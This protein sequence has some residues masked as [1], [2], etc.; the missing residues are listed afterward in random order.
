[1]KAKLLST[2]NSLNRQSSILNEETTNKIILSY[3][4]SVSLFLKDLKE[5]YD[6]Y[7]SNKEKKKRKKRDGGNSKLLLLDNTSSK[8]GA[9][10]AKEDDNNNKKKRKR[11]DDTENKKSSSWFAVLNPINWFSSSSSD[12]KRVKITP[13]VNDQLNNLIRKESTLDTVKLMIEEQGKSMN[14]II[15]EQ[16]RNQGVYNPTKMI[17]SILSSMMSILPI[18]LDTSAYLSDTLLPPS[19]IISKLGEDDNNNVKYVT[20]ESPVLPIFLVSEMINYTQPRFGNL[21]EGVDAVTKKV[22]KEG[23]RDDGNDNN[24]NNNNTEVVVME[25][26][27]G[28]SDADALSLKQLLNTGLGLINTLCVID[29]FE[30]KKRLLFDITHGKVTKPSNYDSSNNNDALPELSDNSLFRHLNSTVSF[31]STPW[32]LFNLSTNYGIN[33]LNKRAMYGL[34]ITGNNTK[35]DINKSLSRTFFEYDDNM[36]SKSWQYI[37]SS[38]TTTSSNNKKSYPY[39]ASGLFI[40]PEIKLK[41][42][43]SDFIG[44]IIGSNSNDKEEEEEVVFFNKVGDRSVQQSTFVMAPNTNKTTDTTTANT[45]SLLLNTE[46]CDISLL[47][48]MCDTLHYKTSKEIEFSEKVTKR[49]QSG[50]TPPITTLSID[51]Y[52]SGINKRYLEDL[53]KLSGVL[54]STQSG[55]RDQYINNVYE[56]LLQYNKDYFVYF[57]PSSTQGPQIKSDLIQLSDKLRSMYGKLSK[58]HVIISYLPQRN[59]LF[60]HPAFTASSN[61]NNNLKFTELVNYYDS[62]SGALKYIRRCILNS[63]ESLLNS[64]ISTK[65]DDNN[66]ADHV[67][68]IWRKFVDRIYM[69]T[70]I[71]LSANEIDKVLR[72]LDK[73]FKKSIQIMVTLDE[74]SENLLRSGVIYKNTIRLLNS[75]EKDGDS[76][77]GSSSKLLSRKLVFIHQHKSIEQL[78]ETV[79]YKKLK[80]D[81]MRPPSL[82]A[83]QTNP[84][85]NGVG[86]FGVSIIMNVTRMINEISRSENLATFAQIFSSVLNETV[87]TS[88]FNCMTEWMNEEGLSNYYTLSS[89]QVKTTAPGS[90]ATAA[91]PNEGEDLDRMDLSIPEEYIKQVTNKNFN[92]DAF[93]TNDSLQI[94]NDDDDDNN[95]EEIT[96]GTKEIEEVKSKESPLGTKDVEDDKVTEKEQVISEE[97]AMLEE[98]RMLY[99]DSQKRDETTQRATTLAG[100][101]NYNYKLINYLKLLTQQT[102]IELKTQ[103]DEIHREIDSLVKK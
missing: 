54:S 1:M 102:R 96:G 24:N 29:S 48:L 89:S 58:K 80:S 71:E 88:Q 22:V 3:Y 42:K 35:L 32:Q 64:D 86:F 45:N 16:Q 77:N 62:V 73:L 103:L 76:G 97:A 65:S 7:I 101:Y 18:S 21:V 70:N 47:E 2:L 44:T 68:S 81:L 67:N 56:I 39:Y 63:V 49:R 98:I 85:I 60:N 69:G 14:L 100:I 4:P 82:S 37:P 61:N 53:I 51:D 38:T 84:T 41:E 31:Y 6:K 8:P 90:A 87:N 17:C 10:G 57:F 46:L 9:P 26:P 13:Q 43:R 19:E 72:E 15:S 75:G 59:A 36:K 12:S 25:E 5:E 52:Y 27:P 33:W 93:T 78:D 34:P 40:T 50:P 11:E 30:A 28:I 95:V 66:T 83:R 74:E 20:H 79:D 99:R 23:S 92:P 55:E 94:E 91:I